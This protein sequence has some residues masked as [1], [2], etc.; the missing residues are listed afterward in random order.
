[1]SKIGG[2]S[3]ENEL[4][5]YSVVLQNQLKPANNNKITIVID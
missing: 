1:M 2:N 3:S 4:L 5:R